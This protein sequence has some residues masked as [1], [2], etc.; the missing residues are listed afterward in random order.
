M[1]LWFITEFLSDGRLVR[2]TGDEGTSY[3]SLVRQPDTV[4]FDVI[5]DDAPS[6]PNQ[7]EL[8]WSSLVTMMPLVQ[9][10][11][12]P[13]AVIMAL[14]EYSPLPASVVAKIKAAVQEFQKQ[15]QANPQPSPMQIIM[16]EK[17]EEVRAEEAKNQLRIAAKQ[18]EN[19]LDVSHKQ[20]LVKIDLQGKI[21]LTR[22]AAWAK[23]QEA[24]TAAM[25]TQTDSFGTAVNEGLV[26][27]V[28]AGM[29]H[30]ATAVSK[31]KCCCGSLQSF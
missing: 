15:Q 13:P 4:K 12:P 14:L 1:L 21:A 10:M 17:S 31:V 19:A 26:Q 18:Q 24:A 5:V 29:A 25:P 3:I 9:A 11:Q 6:S 2:I 22:I 7:K 23:Q 28:K 8:V 20:A 30:A 27:G 16:M